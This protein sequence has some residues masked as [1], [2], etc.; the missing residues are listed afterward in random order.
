MS[1]TINHLYQFGT[2]LV[3]ADQRVVLREGK[4]V[5]LTPK[6]FET[7]LVLIEH[8]GRI[9]EKEELMNRLWPDSF[10]EEANLTFNIQQLRKALGDNARKPVYI[11]TVARRGYRFIATVEEVLTE[12]GALSGHVSLRFNDSKTEV[13]STGIESDIDERHDALDFGTETP[14]EVPP[15]VKKKSTDETV[16]VARS[17]A[18]KRIFLIAAAL[19]AILLTGTVIAVRHFNDSGNNDP[20]NDRRARGGAPALHSLTLERFTGTGRNRHAVISPDGRYVAYSSEVGG[21]HGL[22]LR[23]L[24]TNTNVE[25]ASSS[26]EFF[27]GLAFAHSG[28]YLYF[29]RGKPYPEPL[30]LYRIP[31]IGGTA[32]RLITN[33]QG[34]FSIS[35][36]DRRIAFIRNSHDNRETALMIADADGTNESAL[37]IH[38]WVER[39]YAP[40]FS[41]DGETIACAVGH[42]DSGG[43]EVHVVEFRASDG[44]KNV[45]P[46]ERWF[47]ISR[48]VWLPGKTGLIA[49]GRKSL[50]DVTQLWRISYPGGETSKLTEGLQDYLGV[51]I[52]ADARRAVASQATRISD[53][54]VTPSREPL[55]FRRTAQGVGKSCWTPDGRIVYSSTTSGNADLWIMRQDGTDQRQ[56]TSN[57]ESD[58]DPVVSPDGRYIIYLSNRTGSLHLWRMNID[59]SDQTQITDGGGENFAAI[60]ADGQWVLYNSVNDRHLWKVSI[61]GGEPVRLIERIASFPAV[62]PDGGLVA[63]IGRNER[64]NRTLLVMPFEGGQPLRELDLDPQSLA[65]TRLLWT[66][67]GTALIY[68]ASRDGVTSLFRQPLNGGSSEKL[69]DFDDG[70]IFD[71]NYSRDGEYL[72]VTRGG[73][74]H[75]IVL[76]SNFIY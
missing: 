48:L 45:L 42:S 66:P 40:A 2:F 50:E 28:D 57:P 14:F 32:T 65:A 1:F 52:T 35:S 47:H 41:P 73:W 5:P 44:T 64:L 31:L 56:L 53:V 46:G 24:A 34:T 63:C 25:I 55:N 43:Q 54:W 16:S 21:R 69:F 18:N 49:V 71:F 23:Q 67:D 9:V 76:I 30:V 37:A 60:S 36:D 29:A 3:D 12:T 19:A 15:T 20:N 51:S 38:S 33:L 68:A 72:A 10:V 75:D 22:W 58:Y 26:D 62:S 74:Q 11:E 61:N 4:P 17:I 70:E 6:V 13:S 59:G 8:R 7:L 27:G 39:I